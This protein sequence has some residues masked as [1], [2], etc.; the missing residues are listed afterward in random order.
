MGGERVRDIQENDDTEKS[1][2]SIAGFEY[3]RAEVWP[4]SCILDVRNRCIE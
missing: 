1:G 4:H 3:D 2:A